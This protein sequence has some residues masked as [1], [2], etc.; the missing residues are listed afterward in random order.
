MNSHRFDINNFDD[1]SFFPLV[2]TYFNSDNHSMSDFSFMP[3]DVIDNN[4][5]RLCKRDLLDT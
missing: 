1:P 5:D 2:A 3:I 4:F